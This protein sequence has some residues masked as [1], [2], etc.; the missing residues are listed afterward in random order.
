MEFSITCRNRE[1]TAVVAGV[2]APLL[3]PGDAI[4]LKGVLASGK[5]A[6]VPR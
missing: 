2:L 1:E 5:T 6:F 3:Q 4:L